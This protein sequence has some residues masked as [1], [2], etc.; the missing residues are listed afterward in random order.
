MFSLYLRKF[1]FGQTL[2]FS[3]LLVALCAE[4]FAA[5]F[6]LQLHLLSFVDPR[7]IPHCYD[8]VDRLVGLLERSG[9]FVF[10]SSDDLLGNLLDRHNF[11]FGS[12]A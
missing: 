10:H 6:S 7:A 2:S 5:A 4:L 8:A 11:Q 12:I 1:Q 3:P 9:Y